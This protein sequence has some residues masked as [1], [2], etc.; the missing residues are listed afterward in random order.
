MPQAPL[1]TLTDPAAQ[2]SASIAPERG[3]IVTSFKVGQCELL[4]LDQTTFTDPA[5][6]VRG[7]IPILFPSPGKLI[8]DTWQRDGQTGNMKQH[9]FARTKSWQVASVSERTATLQLQSDTET[10]AQYPW[11]FLA[12]L[13]VSL[14]GLH[15]A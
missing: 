10:L 14:S 12:T 5:K 1:I 4:Y 3:A 8:N 7:G 2:S 13:E 15:Y 9:G 6:N 11:P